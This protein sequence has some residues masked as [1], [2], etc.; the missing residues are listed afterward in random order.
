MLKPI[1]VLLLAA[2]YG[3]RLQPYTNSWPKCLMP[4][5]GKPLLEHWLMS[6]S[7]I[8][9][10]KVLVNTHYLADTVQ[11]FL[12]RPAFKQWV[13]GIY[14]PELKGTAGTIRVNAPAL[15]DTTILLAHADNFCQC[16]FNDFLKYHQR[17]R[18]KYCL[19]TM[20]T[21]HSKNPSSC[22][23]VQLDENGVVIRFYEKPKDPPGSIANG[24]VYLLEPEV[25]E[26]ICERP[27]VT[28][29]STEVLPQFI[30]RIAAWHNNCTHI[31]IGSIEGLLE[32]ESV[33][34]RE[35]KATTIKRDNW[36][37]KFASHPIHNQI[38]FGITA[39]TQE[40]ITNR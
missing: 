4:I 17:L 19:M 31:D 20:M 14:E 26:W 29:F 3:S 33:A 11:S 28:D 15:R 6:V 38:K 25:L 22:G 18:P 9:T 27:E 8:Y 7:K 2:G 5:K 12:D 37:L 39:E 1:S 34:P 23:I 10:T 30:G 24:A 13:R 36:S 21:F 35:I 32:A 16:N 40:S